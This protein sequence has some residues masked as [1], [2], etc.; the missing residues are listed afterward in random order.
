MRTV[1][2]LI[3]GLVGLPILSVHAQDAPAPQQ[4][5]AQAESYAD[6]AA[7]VRRTLH[8]HG[9]ERGYGPAPVKACLRTTVAEAR[10]SPAT[11]ARTPAAGHDHGRMH[12]NQ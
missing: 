12:K 4:L 9:I 10:N 6:C 3:S 7:R 2:L 5:S 8:D 11:G 1:A